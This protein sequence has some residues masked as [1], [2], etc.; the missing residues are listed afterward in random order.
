MQKYWKNFHNSK[1]ISIKNVLRLIRGKI[2]LI[3]FEKVIHNF[4][5]SKKTVCESQLAPLSISPKKSNKIKFG[6]VNH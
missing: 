5:K 4:L 2:A 1:F 6:D 3:F